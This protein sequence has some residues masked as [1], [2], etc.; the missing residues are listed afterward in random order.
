[1]AD[2]HENK[3]LYRSL[4]VSYGILA[5]CALELFPP[6]NDLLQLT[7]M[8]STSDA[9]GESFGHLL[10]SENPLNKVIVSVEL[11]VFLCGVMAIDTVLVFAAERVI[12]SHFEGAA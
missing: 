12:R 11:P 4:Q 3:L 2:I 5:V 6:L 8:P 7:A 10:N 9:T 1:M